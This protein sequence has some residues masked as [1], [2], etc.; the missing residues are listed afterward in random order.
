[1]E[2]R[3]II[4]LSKQNHDQIDYHSKLVLLG[5]CFA[6]SIGSKLDYFK[7]QSVVNPFGILFHP[8]AIENF[9]ENV[10]NRRHFDENDI[11]NFNGIWKSFDAHSIL[12]QTTKEELLEVMNAQIE[13]SYSNFQKATHI[14][15]TYGT[16]WVYRFIENDKVVSNCHKIP[17]KKFLKELMSPTEI[18][19]SVEAVTELIKLINP[20]VS[21]IFTVS[22]VRH[23]KDGFVENNRSKAHLT[24][25]LHKAVEPRKKRY[26]FPSYELMI[27]DLRDYRFYSE[28]M[29]HPNPIAIDYIWKSF[30]EV[31]HSEST[32]PIMKEVSAVQKGL[33]HSPFF[34]ESAEHLEFIAEIDKK[35]SKLQQQFSHISF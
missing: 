19:Q 20:E 3:T 12:N 34:P 22:P 24:A 28:D 5:S 29:V 17:Q 7:F 4:P 31:W 6:E 10:I 11:F 16:S 35:K 25:G 8:W 32:H 15:I 21:V 23:I 30:T 1:M 26:Y 2:F 9:I 27:D 13:L 18:T 14:I 33:S